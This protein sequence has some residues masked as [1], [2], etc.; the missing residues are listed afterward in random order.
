MALTSNQTPKFKKSNHEIRLNN[1]NFRG[2]FL[3]CTLKSTRNLTRRCLVYFPK[4]H[5]DDQP[6]LEAHRTQHLARKGSDHITNAVAL[7]PNCHQRCHRPSDREAFTAAVYAKID[8]LIR[9]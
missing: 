9:E 4:S 6:L 3:P 8:R 2:D 7:C 5:C 1:S